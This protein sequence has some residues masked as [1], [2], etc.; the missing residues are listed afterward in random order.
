[1]TREDVGSRGIGDLLLTM[2]LKT[3]RGAGL[4]RTWLCCIAS[5]LM[6]VELLTCCCWSHPMLV[7]FLLKEVKKAYLLNLPGCRM[8]LD[9]E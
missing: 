6:I 1:M 2:G 4:A 8:I 5:L 3:P 7:E 9:R